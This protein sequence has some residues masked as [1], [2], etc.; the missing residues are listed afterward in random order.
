MTEPA[1][2]PVIACSLINSELAKR[3]ETI[4]HDLFRHAERVQELEDGFAWRFPSADPWAATAFAFIDTERQCCPFFT[5]EVVIEPNNGPLWLR[6]RGSD[7]VKAYISTV[8]G[9]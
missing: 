4:R 1:R 7:D 8:F 2:T 6:L 9:G 3:Q 5:F